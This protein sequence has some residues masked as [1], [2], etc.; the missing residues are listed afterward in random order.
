M[1]KYKVDG[2]KE[3]LVGGIQETTGK[4]I[5]NDE[6]ELKGKVHKGMGFAKNVT[7]DVVD[8]LDDVK[9]K[10]VGSVKEATGKVTNNRTL[11]LRGELQRRKVRNPR[12][13]KIIIGLGVVTGLLVGAYI[14]DAIITKN[15][16][17]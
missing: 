8:E 11:A 3:K 7:G 12:T 5:N 9:D 14:L 13:N 15:D 17:S 6:M 1:N 2:V 16:E 10:V 4:I